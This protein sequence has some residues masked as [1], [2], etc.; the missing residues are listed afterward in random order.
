VDAIRDTVR[1][2]FAKM[3]LSWPVPLDSHASFE[4]M[5]YLSSFH[6]MA[7]RLQDMAIEN[8]SNSSLPSLC[9]ESVF[10]TNSDEIISNTH[11][12]IQRCEIKSD[13]EQ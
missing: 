5:V 4:V 9:R 13:F 3:P 8:P 1:L 11:L 12:G 7:E 6:G 10:L 2:R